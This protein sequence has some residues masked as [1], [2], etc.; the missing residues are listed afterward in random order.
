M[1]LCDLIPHVDGFSGWNHAD[2]IRFFAWYL[3]VHRGQEHFITADIRR[4]FDE[5][6]VERPPNISSFITAM[7]ERRPREALRN[8]DGFRLERRVR[9]HFNSKYGQRTSTV[10]VDKLLSELPGKVPDLTERTYLNETLTCLRAGA[11]RATV[12]M[13]W[14]MAYSHLCDYVLKKHLSAFNGELPKINSKAKLIVSLDDFAELKES[15]VLRCCRSANIT[16][17]NMD[18]VLQ[19][20]LKRRNTAAHPSQIL[21][22]RLKAEETVKDLVENVVL[23]LV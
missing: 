7:V 14:N 10:V 20:K 3:H 15:E 23:K 11:F 16:P 22:D 4:C 19:E 1:D 12:V 8:K 13:A 18:V 21:V 17:K 9:E 5:V 2:K 6:H